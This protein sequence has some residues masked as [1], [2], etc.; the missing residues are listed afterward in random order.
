MEFKKATLKDVESI[1]NI[2]NKAQR[3]FKEQGIDQWQDNYPNNQD[4]ENDINNKH[5]YIL[6]DDD[7]VV[8]TTALSF[9]GESSYDKIYNGQWLCEDSDYGVI[10]RMAVDDSYKGL[11]LGLNIINKTEKICIKKGIKS[12]KVD[13]HEDNKS[14]QRLLEK[15]G[16]KYCGMIYLEDDSVRIAFEKILII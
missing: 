14:M 9:N 4:I 3:Y 7:K 6:I 15:S 5:S 10:H 13:T 1:M 16:Y 2:I 11:G 8:G 12:I